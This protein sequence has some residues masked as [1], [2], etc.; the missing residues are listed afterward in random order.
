MTHLAT[1]ALNFGRGYA[2]SAKLLQSFIHLI[3][4][5]WFDDRDDLLHSHRSEQKK[6]GN[7]EHTIP[8]SPSNQ[9]SQRS[10]ERSRPN[11]GA[12]WRGKRQEM[13]LAS[14]GK[15]I[16]KALKDWRRIGR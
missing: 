9:A 3:E 1:Y 6:R 7:V 8:D 14:S 12:A 2:L 13:G 15:P 5:E 11:G 16:G 10:L 4:F